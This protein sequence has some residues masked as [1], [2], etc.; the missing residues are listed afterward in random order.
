MDEQKRLIDI[1]PRRLTGAGAVLLAGLGAIA[2]LIGLH[3]WAASAAV[4][5]PKGTL[6]A[7]KLSTAGSLAQ[8]FS[9]LLLLAAAGTSLLVYSIRRQRTDDYQGHYRVWLWAALCWFLFATD[10]AV[11]LNRML[12]QLLVQLTGTP[13]WK[14][15]VLWWIVPYTV[16]F[17]A[18]GSRLVLDMW[19]CR[20]AIA[21]FVM[22]SAGY[23]V[24]L[25]AGLGYLPEDVAG[26]AVAIHAGAI[27]L[28][29]LLLF[30][31]MLLQARFVVL[32]F[33][34]LLPP[35]KPK[36]AKPKKN[37]LKKAA[38]RAAEPGDEDLEGDLWRRVDAPQGT[39]QPVLRRAAAAPVFTPVEDEDD[40]VPNPTNRKLTKQEKRAL[41][42]RLLRERAERE[43]KLSKW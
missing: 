32:D 16:V 33:E 22:A 27:V 37:V 20:L 1:I 11:G 24:A 40:D 42:E 28:G 36:A 34:G 6:A 43:K 10:V 17:A 31:A 9:S 38:A 7:L 19:P 39:P 5:F 14:D 2:G 18:L 21:A 12:Q 3:F 15:G 35:R 25:L 4:R 41:R 13:L 8:W 23:G 30:L 26:N 29:H